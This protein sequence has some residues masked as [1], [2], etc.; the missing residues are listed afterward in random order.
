[1]ETQG[2][3]AFELAIEMKLHG[4][5]P[6][7]Q[8]PG[9]EAHLASCE[10][11]QRFLRRAEE[12]RS[13]MGATTKALA[14]AVPP[15]R[16]W[17]RMQRMIREERMGLWLRALI[18]AGLVPLLGFLSGSFVLAAVCIGTVGGGLL[19][20]MVLGSRRAARDVALVGSSKGEVL[21]VYRQ[22]LERRIA[23]AMRMRRVLPVLGVMEL[24]LTS[25][26]VPW[27][28]SLDKQS[29]AWFAVGLFIV[30]MGRA[31]YLS[32]RVLP[33][34]RREQQASAS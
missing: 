15:A 8:G 9:L 34:L 33:A 2:C 21:A 19:L 1:M 32:L 23:R 16:T 6:A 31:L 26:R 22:L 29:M 11:C 7:D 27:P 5:L 3:D 17:E 12:T 30:C 10:R 13:V 14:D 24:V 18:L 25:S 4:A 28:K 20:L